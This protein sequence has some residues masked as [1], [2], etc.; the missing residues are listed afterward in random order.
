M[1]NKHSVNQILYF[2]TATA[3]PVSEGTGFTINAPTDF[4]ED[5][6]WGDTNKTY[7]PGLTDFSAQLMKHFDNS[8]TELN[9]AATNKTLS[10]FYW[11]PDRSDSANFW[12]WQGYVAGPNVNAGGLNQII[13]ATYDIRAN[14][15]ITRTVA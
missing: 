9:D 11:Y 12:E 1:A 7:I 4:A 13:A 8:T 3:T 15:A 14:T 5:S 6:S 10:K 2:G